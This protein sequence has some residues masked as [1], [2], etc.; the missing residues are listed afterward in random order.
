M[1][2]RYSFIMGIVTLLTACGVKH[3]LQLPKKQ[4]AP[5]EKIQEAP[6]SSTNTTI[7]SK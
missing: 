5:S 3:E 7:D 1:I 6:L 4:E 2:Y